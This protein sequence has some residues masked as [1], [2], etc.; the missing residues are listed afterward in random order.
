MLIITRRERNPK[1]VKF[2]HSPASHPVGPDLP[3]PGGFAATKFDCDRLLA[4][5]PYAELVPF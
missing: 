5:K 1:L 4:A 3:P 2:R